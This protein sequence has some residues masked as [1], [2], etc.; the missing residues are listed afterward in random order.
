MKYL[1][2]FEELNPETYKSAAYKLKDLGHIDRSKK[3][4]DYSNKYLIMNAFIDNNKNME[5]LKFS[6]SHYKIIYGDKDSL[7]EA[8]LDNF[9]NLGD[10]YISIKFFFAYEYEVINIFDVIVGIYEQFDEIDNDDYIFPISIDEN[11]S[12]PRE[13]IMDREFYNAFFADK[14]SAYLFKK[15]LVNVLLEKVNMSE[16]ISMFGG[17]SFQYERYIKDVESINTNK[18]ISQVYKTCE[19]LN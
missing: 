11:L 12:Y 9:D 10:P 16:L 19:R 13:E 18:L 2:L 14:R 6:Y 7:E 5:K 15:I 17:S 4:L 8:M 3:I 1:K